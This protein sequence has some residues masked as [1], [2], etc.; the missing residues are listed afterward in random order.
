MSLAWLLLL[1]WLFAFANKF[2]S[3]FQLFSDSGRVVVGVIVACVVSVVVDGVREGV[4]ARGVVGGVV[5][6]AELMVVACAVVV[7]GVDFCF[8]VF[9]VVCAV[10][11]VCGDSV[12][13]NARMS[14]WRV[15]SLSCC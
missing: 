12:V 8:F 15:L 7:G 6:V 1:V 9:V 5:V 13:M 3:P 14:V 4:V 11:G 2:V 10:H